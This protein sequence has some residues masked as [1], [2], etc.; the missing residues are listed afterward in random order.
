[1]KDDRDKP[2]LNI[3]NN[4]ASAVT[5]AGDIVAKAAT[6]YYANAI[7]KGATSAEADGA[8]DQLIDIAIQLFK[9]AVGR[10]PEEP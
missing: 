7:A 10:C 1:M 6:I 4:V 3:A 2:E 9:A 8:A 5:I